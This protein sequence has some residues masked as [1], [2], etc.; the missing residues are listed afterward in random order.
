MVM[1]ISEKAKEKVISLLRDTED[2]INYPVT[3]K[4]GYGS[5]QEKINN[6][7]KHYLAHRISYQIYTGE[8]INSNDIIC[9]K[10]DNPACINPKHLFKG[11]HL[12][13]IRDKV[14]KN[15]QAKG[16][17]NGRY[18]DGRASDNI[19]RKVHNHGRKL[20]EEQVLK[21]KELKHKGYKLKEISALLNVSYQ[22]VRDISCGRIYR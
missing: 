18:I 13:N 16:I 8:D 6:V 21:I 12:D 7:K 2:C 3:N 22:T 15:R 4:D 14:A 9:H 17:K 11:T 19:I 10:C 20:K 1:I 5:I